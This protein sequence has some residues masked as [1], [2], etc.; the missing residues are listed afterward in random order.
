M[1]IPINDFHLKDRIFR[2]LFT[3]YPKDICKLFG[4][5]ESVIKVCTMKTPYNR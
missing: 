1:T 5:K 3:L 4:I 2:S